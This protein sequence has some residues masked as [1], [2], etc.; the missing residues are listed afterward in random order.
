MNNV[1]DGGRRKDTGLGTP[2]EDG[3]AGQGTESDMSERRSG[4]GAPGRRRT[5]TGDALSGPAG[6]SGA[7]N[8]GDAGD[9]GVLESVL[10]TA[11][12]ADDL[13]PD[14]E[15]RAVAAFRAAHSAGGRPARTRT[16]RRDDWRR[17]AEKRRSRR[18]VK[19]TFGVV[20]AGL[21]LGGVAVAAV[22]SSTDATGSGSGT[23]RGTARPSAV[24]PDR[25]G[26]AG[27]SPSSSAG[28]GRPTDRPANAQDTA[29]HCRAYEQVQGRGKALDS[30]AWQRL[31]T[32][33]GGDDRVA[34]YCSEQLTG[35]GRSAKSTPG[36]SQANGGQDNG[37]DKDKA[38][39]KDR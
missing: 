28:G 25:P 26:D 35:T 32:A 22:G 3:T 31:V 39:D 37:K 30:T 1:G 9:A 33:A 5:Q 36:N 7:G 14:A 6:A 24:A 8:P 12:R 21:A 19:L 11:I 16:R 38:K 10:A 17:L 29:A 34:A 18:P 27:S 13:A 23:G 4:G 2:H 15:Q 20:F